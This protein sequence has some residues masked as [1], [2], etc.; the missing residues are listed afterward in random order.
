MY[1]IQDDRHTKPATPEAV[2]VVSHEAERLHAEYGDVVEVEL[3]VV[4]GIAERQRHQ[5][6]LE[7]E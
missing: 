2:Y 6:E 5:V 1:V 7:D 4:Q 3:V